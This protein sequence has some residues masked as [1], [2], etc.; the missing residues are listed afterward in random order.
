MQ[1][2]TTLSLTLFAKGFDLPA[3]EFG[4]SGQFVLNQVIH[5]TLKPRQTIV[6]VI[7]LID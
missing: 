7:R 4:Q 2:I 5:D 3:K 6:S 1:V